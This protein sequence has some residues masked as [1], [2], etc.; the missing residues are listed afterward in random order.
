M[1]YRV[2]ISEILKATIHIEANNECEA[3]LFYHSY[4]CFSNNICSE[5]FIYSDVIAKS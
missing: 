1:K 4:R 5:F 2:D 3:N